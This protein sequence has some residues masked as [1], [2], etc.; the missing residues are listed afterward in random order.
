MP[1]HSAFKPS[2]QYVRNIEHS[3]DRKMPSSHTKQVISTDQA[4]APRKGL[5]SQAII[6]G[7]LVFCSGQTPVDPKTPGQLS[8]GGIRENTVSTR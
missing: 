7:N 3:Q 1:S 5:Y 8:D 6:A 2:S 4:P